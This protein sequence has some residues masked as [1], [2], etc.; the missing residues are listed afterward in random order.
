MIRAASLLFVACGPVPL[1]SD[2]PPPGARSLF[3]GLV[4]EGRLEGLEA[5]DLDGKAIE[6]SYDLSRG[7]EVRALYY[8]VALADLRYGPG[9]HPSTC[10]ADGVLA[11]CDPLP[12]PSFAR[13][14]DGAGWRSID[15][16]GAAGD[17][18]VLR[19][20]L[21][22]WRSIVETSLS[23]GGV[24]I[25]GAIPMGRG[26]VA[27][28]AGGEVFDVTTTSIARRED[29][30]DGPW[31]AAESDGAGGAWLLDATGRIGSWPGGVE[32][33]PRDAW[34]VASTRFFASR[35]EGD[36]FVVTTTAG[37]A[38]SALRRFRGGVWDRI[39]L[40][41]DCDP[42]LQVDPPSL[43]HARRIASDGSAVYVLGFCPDQVGRFSAEAFVPIE[44][45]F[46]RLAAPSAIASVG[47]FGVLAGTR[48]GSINR[49]VGSRFEAFASLDQNRVTAIGGFEDVLFVEDAAKTV[50]RIEI[51][52]TEASVC[53][54]TPSPTNGSTVDMV[55]M[56]GGVA[57]IRT[58]GSDLVILARP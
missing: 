28:G 53:L 52:G 14:T 18:P 46:G 23:T 32:L 30:L 43:G 21:C 5:F 6:R 37:G 35:A 45:D 20:T 15:P 12:P 11:S 51:D 22:G 24:P 44:G 31:A 2:P 3:L 10:E 29:A 13:A 19:P 41:P 27:F 56:Q 33:A 38:V 26:A 57:L 1:Q 58:D 25:V 54:P 17:T 47:S 40:P 48:L 36:L 16:A 7:S 55:P 34:E 49:L 50:A 8:P 39:A 42:D 4:V 9:S